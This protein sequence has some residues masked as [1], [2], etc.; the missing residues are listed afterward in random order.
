[1]IE[2]VES[3]KVKV[4]GTDIS[5]LLP[6]TKPTGKVRLKRR[7][8]FYEYGE[9]FATRKNA[10]GLTA[11]IEWQIGYDLPKNTDNAKKTT[12]SKLIFRNYKGKA[13]Y[14]YEL[15]EIIYYSYKIGL[16]TGQDIKTLK[17]QINSVRDAELIENK[18]ITRSNSI[19]TKIGGLQFYEMEVTYP[20]VVHKFGNY[21][22][23]AEVINR[24]KQRAV[25]IQPMLYVCLPITSV[26][27]TTNVLGRALDTKECSRWK[28]GQSEAKLALELFR[29]FGML[30][31]NHKFDILALLGVLF[32]NVA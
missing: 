23:Y 1:M 17:R 8:S 2:H 12:L 14:P 7:N 15:S 32:P 30:S 9:P 13:K 29:V 5:V 31:V 21:D 3:A 26:E 25:G 19:E 11:Y 10:I 4:S 20:L 28:I 16:I 6:M 27:F 24:E 18:K 22:I